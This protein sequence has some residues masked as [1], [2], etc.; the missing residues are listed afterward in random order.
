MLYDATHESVQ[1]LIFAACRMTPLTSHRVGAKAKETKVR[2]ANWDNANL[3]SS[4]RDDVGV[5]GLVSQLL[6]E[7][8]M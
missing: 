4:C 6:V 7:A 5:V 8:E 3:N 2:D 1:K